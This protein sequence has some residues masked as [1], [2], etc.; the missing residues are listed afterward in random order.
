M[1]IDH[2]CVTSELF[3]EGAEGSESCP[4]LLI[5][6]RDC[7]GRLGRA[8]GAAVEFTNSGLRKSCGYLWCLMV[9]AQRDVGLR[10]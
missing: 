5:S 7:D 2:S 6:V 3:V 9:R 1:N 10:R 8:G 4:L